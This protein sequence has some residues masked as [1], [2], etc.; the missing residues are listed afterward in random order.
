MTSGRAAISSALSIISSGVTHTGQP[1][2]WIISIASGSSW[3]MP[4]RMIEW[5]WPPHTSMI[6]QRRVVT[7]WIWSM[8]RLARS[9]SLNSSRYFMT[10]LQVRAVCVGDV[11]TRLPR[12]D[13]ESVAELL[14]EHAQLL[15]VSER[16]L[17]RLLVE[18]S[19]W[20]SRRA[21]STYSPSCDVG[22][23]LQADVLAHAAEV[24]LGHRRAV[25]FF[26]ADHAFPERPGT[27]RPP[28]S[29]LNRCTRISEPPL[30]A[31]DR[32]RARRR[33]AEVGG[34][35]SARKPAASSRSRDHA[36]SRAFWN[37]P[38]AKATVL[39][40][41]VSSSPASSS[42]SSVRAARRCRPRLRGSGRATRRDR[43]TGP[44]GRRRSSGSPVRRR[45][46]GTHRCDRRQP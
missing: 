3:S 19:G 39:R 1:G 42:A 17:R 23:V 36:S 7:A 31:A 16:P 13:R 41:S 29:S 32:A 40:V 24:D 30:R 12:S 4:W 14:L 8:S 20:R 45:R 37:T 25:T 43:D 35:A 10:R 15:E 9:G 28:P 34:G 33:S 44:R 18:T 2:P 26:D 21:R 46:I 5:V 38:P 27:W 11:D 6:A 22:H